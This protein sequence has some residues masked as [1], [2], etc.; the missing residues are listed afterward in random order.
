M[1][2]MQIQPRFP[3][4]NALGLINNTVPA[5]WFESAQDPLFPDFSPGWM[6]MTGT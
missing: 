2:E 6:C 5:V 3:E 1:L 4:T